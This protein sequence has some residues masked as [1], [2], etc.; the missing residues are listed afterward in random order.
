LEGVRVKT[1]VTG[2]FYALRGETCDP[3]CDPTSD[4]FCDPCDST[5]RWPLP[6]PIGVSVGHPAITAGT[7][8]ARVTDGTNVFML[9][10]NH[11]LANI[12][13]ANMGDP[14]LQP[15]RY[16]GGVESA[17]AVAYLSD[18]EEIQWCYYSWI[19]LICPDTNTIDA[20]IAHSTPG[21]IGFE[22]PT[23][24]DGS[25]LGYGAP[26]LT[27]HA[28]YGDPVV[29]GD[30]SLSLLLHQS[31]QKFGRTTGNTIGTVDAINATVNVCYDDSCDKVARFV[32]QLIITPGS[33]SAG[34]DSGSLIVT[35]DADPAE[36]A[37]PVGLLFA[38]SNT[39]TIANRI[40]LVLN[41]FDVTIDSGAPPTLKTVSVTPASA[42]IGVGETQQFTATGHYSDGSTSDIAS[43]SDVSW[44]SSDTTV[45]TI[46]PN[47]LA[48]GV[49]E[50]KA[51]ITATYE[52]ITSDPVALTISTTSPEL[53]S[54]TVTP[55][56]A[57]IEVGGDQRFTAVGH[58]SDGSTPDI[59]SSV[60]WASSV[61]T[62]ATIV[63]G[64]LA[65]GVG[66]GTTYITAIQDEITSNQATL[67]VT[68]NNTYMHVGDLDGSSQ[69]W[70]WGIWKA[71]I[72]ITIH[73]SNEQ[74]V[75]NATVVGSFDDCP[76][77]VDCEKFKC[78][79]DGNKGT[80][81]VVG[82]QSYANHLTFTVESVSHATLEYN[83]DLN[84]DPDEDS[85]PAGT[86]IYVPRP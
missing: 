77:G 76:G 18:Y 39:N 24:K 79:T 15:G 70:R 22:T 29:I 16:D 59:T 31:V 7:F 38:G 9:S 63:P 53:E 60:S 20:A 34:G 44:A 86:S 51:N 67:K 85:N 61:P 3:T 56:D 52:G 55:A 10:N 83:P 80:C 57:A 28:A 8:G 47:G 54:I 36:N 45:A 75:G 5:K 68:V 84:R 72:D 50:G 11:V 74:P 33:F 4:P 78:T 69:K 73:D 21:E 13:Q 19:F 1:Q 32:N 81:R 14:I 6:V 46:D 49:G 27:I 37:K 62:V 35:K 66:E 71:I 23:D 40:D 26:K 64:G 43:D 41:R 65:T 17:D 25:P 2:K 12:N 30:E 42:T 82:Y 48:T 58:Y